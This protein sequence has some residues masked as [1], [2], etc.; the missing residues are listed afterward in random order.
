MGRLLRDYFVQSFEMHLNHLVAYNCS[1]DL[2]KVGADDE[3]NNC[4]MRE[5]WTA[6]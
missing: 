4:G 5:D 3:V 1:E 2:L 6:A